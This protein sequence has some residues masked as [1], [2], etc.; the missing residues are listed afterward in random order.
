MQVSSS[1]RRERERLGLSQEALAER[2][3]ISRQTVSNWETGKTYPD[4]ESLLLM[5]EVFDVSLDA[6]VK[7]DEMVMTET[8][9]R[10]RKRMGGYGLIMAACNVVGMVGLCV[11]V[12]LFHDKPVILVCGFIWFIAFWV[13]SIFFG[14]R[15]ARIERDNDLVTY[16]EVLAFMQ[17]GVRRTDEAG[18]LIPKWQRALVKLIVGGCVGAGAA[19]IVIALLELL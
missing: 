14:L 7:G 19:A 8:I 17:D 18:R 10:D 13:A 3:Y 4:I 1:I 12:G 6:L 2:I 9:E 16:G 5:A 11:A 15:I